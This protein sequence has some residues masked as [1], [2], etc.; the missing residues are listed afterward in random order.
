M[1]LMHT[2]SQLSYWTAK[3]LGD[4][5]LKAMQVRGRIQA[6][7]VADIVIFD[8]KTV[9]EH[10]DY[11]VGKNGLASTGIPHVLVNGT[12]VMKD[13][14]VLKGVTPGQP[15]RFPVE[16]KGRFV[17]ATKKMWL[18]QHTIDSGGVAPRA[19]KK[20][21]APAEKKTSFAPAK[22]VDQVVASS[23]QLFGPMN[24]VSLAC[25]RNPYD[26]RQQ[27]SGLVVDFFPGQLHPTPVRPVSTDPYD[28]LSAASIQARR[29]TGSDSKAAN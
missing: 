22:P 15:I 11:K 29:S 17:P 10:A 7:M 28:P 27:T 5:G 25:C 9:T 21:S 19:E 4:T 3:H 24:Y 20:A 14:K 8:A 23:L 2:L 16:D 1:P 6:G 18:Q 26:K 13:S 12:V